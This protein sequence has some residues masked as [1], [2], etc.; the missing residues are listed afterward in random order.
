[1]HASAQAGHISIV[2]SSVLEVSVAW[3]H[4][5]DGCFLAI[6]YK[7]FPKQPCPESTYFRRKLISLCRLSNHCFGI[8]VPDELPQM[9]E[10]RCWDTPASPSI[11]RPEYFE[12]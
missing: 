10:N 9:F 3:W 5:A 4:S 8:P 2:L 6:S 12:A 1:M 11:P 7:Y